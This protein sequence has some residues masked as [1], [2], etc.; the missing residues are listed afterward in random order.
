MEQFD[1][2]NHVDSESLEDAEGE[3]AISNNQYFLN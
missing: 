2:F 1:W 3:P